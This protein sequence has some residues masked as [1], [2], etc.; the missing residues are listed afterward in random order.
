[1]AIEH[2]SK[3]L[4]ILVVD[5]FST[6]RRIVRNV[7]M[8][9]GFKNIEEAEDGNIALE[10][11]KTG[12]FQVVIADW[13]MPNMMGV[14]LLKLLRKDEALKSLPFLMVTTDMQN[15]KFL[16]EVKAEEANYIIKPFTAELLEKKLETIL[17]NK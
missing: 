6:M 11:L 10:K 3:T 16:D 12:E 8:Q 17:S 2:I 5:D 7:L 14:D 1:M 13:N 9:L 4:K 15:E